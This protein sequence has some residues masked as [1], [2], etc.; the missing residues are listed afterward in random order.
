MNSQSHIILRP[1]LTPN[2]FSVRL[3]RRVPFLPDVFAAH[4]SAPLLLRPPICTGT[5]TD[6]SLQ[7]AF[8]NPQS[9]QN[10]FADLHLSRISLKS[11]PH[12]VRYATSPLTPPTTS[13]TVPSPLTQPAHPS[14]R[15]THTLYPS[16]TIISRSHATK[17]T[18][19][20][21]IDSLSRSSS[22]SLSPS[23]PFSFLPCSLPHLFLCFPYF[24]FFPLSGADG[25][26]G[27]AGGLARVM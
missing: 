22:P 5:F 1:I 11:H 23:L 8:A 21:Q 12:T 15:T 9:P 17:P 4:L 19:N 6:P 27:R 25:G 10:S 2:P 24:T 3:I 13:N 20:G 16:K 14:P 26:V 18:D 7:G